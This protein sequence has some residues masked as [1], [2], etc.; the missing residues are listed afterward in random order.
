MVP[1]T[2]NSHNNRGIIGYLTIRDD[3][4]KMARNLLIIGLI[5]SVVSV[6]IFGYVLPSLYE[7]D[8]I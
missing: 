6:I 2:N 8:L 5:M 3:D 7:G 1:N 4:P